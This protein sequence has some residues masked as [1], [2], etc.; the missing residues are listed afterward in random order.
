MLRL[1]PDG[2]LR[3]TIPRG[4][5]RAEGLRFVE[6]QRAWIE[7]ERVRLAAAQGSRTWGTGTAIRL[8]GRL[9]TLVVTRSVEGSRVSYADRTLRVPRDADVRSFVEDDLRDLARDE[10][11]PRLL[12]LAAQHQLDVR[13][14]TIRNQRS[15]WGS[16]SPNGSIALNFRLVQMPPEVRDYVLVHELMHLRQQNHSRRFWRL[17]AAACP[18]FREAERWLKTEGRLLF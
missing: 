10:L 8:R 13:R 3:L 5:S 6:R 11:V 17:V 1:R 12:E 4:G 16:C 2:R 7:Q 18:D 14:V 15:R 9:E